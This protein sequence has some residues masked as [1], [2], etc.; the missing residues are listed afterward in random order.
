[1]DAPTIA[2][3]MPVIFLGYLTIGGIKTGASQPLL[4]DTHPHKNYERSDWF[5]GIKKVPLGYPRG[6]TK[7]QLSHVY[8]E[9]LSIL[10]GFPELLLDTLDMHLNQEH[11]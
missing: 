11:G 6:T 8:N 7:L 9:D 5:S 2:H 10:N 3:S 1:M 4:G